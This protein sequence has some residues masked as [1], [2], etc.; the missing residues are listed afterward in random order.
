[1]AGIRLSELNPYV[2]QIHFADGMNPRNAE[3]TSRYRP[4]VLFEEVDHMPTKILMRK[5]ARQAGAA[6]IM[7]T[8][9]G[10]LSMIDIERY[11]LGDN[12]PFLGKLTMEDIALIE[13]GA[14]SSGQTVRLIEKLIGRE[15][16]SSRLERSI[17]QIGITLGGIAQLGT[18]ASVGA[19][20]AAVAGREIVLGR[21]PATGRYK[22]SPQ[23]VFR[24][25]EP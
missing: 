13:N 21:G 5:L 23:S 4:N 14:L 25:Q 19:A 12:E 1:M 2:K 9:T 10:D 11:D 7:A 18:T 6:L 3:L 22:I 20:Y 8:D 15:N 24:L 16:I 17:G